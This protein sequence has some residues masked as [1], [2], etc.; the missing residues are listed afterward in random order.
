MAHCTNVRQLEGGV[1]TR[2]D[3]DEVLQ[4]RADGVPSR[5]ADLS[6]HADP[7]GPSTR[8]RCQSGLRDLHIVL[9]CIEARSN[10]ADN[11]AIHD[12]WKAAL[13]LREALRCD[14]RNAA[15]VDSVLERLARLLEQRR[16]AGFAGRQPAVASA[17]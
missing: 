12:D 14:R 13:H 5:S 15:V 8:E 16:C 2:D 3:G 6:L 7:N 4:E 9:R 10:G 11:L 17:F 1:R